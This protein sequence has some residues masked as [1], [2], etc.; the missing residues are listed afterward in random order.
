MF[1]QLTGIVVNSTSVERFVK[2]NG[3]EGRKATIHVRRVSNE[4]HPEEVAVKLTNEQTQYA[5]LPVGTFV[6]VEYFNRVFRFTD[7]QGRRCLG[8]DPCA[9]TIRLVAPDAPKGL[10]GDA[11]GKEALPVPAVRGGLMLNVA[12]GGEAL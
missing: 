12:T 10:N 8:N 4:P 3:E 5:L 11:V 2:K 7:K 1:K 9:R 6:E